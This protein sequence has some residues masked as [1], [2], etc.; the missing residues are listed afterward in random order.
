MFRYR[1][2]CDWNRSIQRMRSKQAHKLEREWYCLV[3]RNARLE[4]AAEIRRREVKATFWF[5]RR[6]RERER[7]FAFLCEQWEVGESEVWSSDSGCTGRYPIWRFLLM[8]KRS[9]SRP[10][11]VGASC[12]MCPA[13]ALLGITHSLV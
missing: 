3:S 9:Y 4:F 8:E 5:E 7:A 11:V 13:T 6:E 2:G 10:P 1:F 12:R